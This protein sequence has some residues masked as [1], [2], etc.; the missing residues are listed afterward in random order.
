MACSGRKL[1]GRGRPCA[2]SPAGGCHQNCSAAR[3]AP[4]NSGPCRRG[5]QK[6][7]DAANA[8]SFR[9]PSRHGLGLIAPLALN[10]QSGLR[11]CARRFFGRCGL[12]PASLGRC[13]PA[14]SGACPI[15]AE[16]PCRSL[17]TATPPSAVRLHAR[18]VNQGAALFRAR[19][20]DGRRGGLRHAFRA[21]SDRCSKVLPASMVRS[22]GSRWPARARA[23]GWRAQAPLRTR[24]RRPDGPSIWFRARRR[25]RF[26]LGQAGLSADDA[27]AVL[28]GLRLRGWRYDKY[29]TKLAADKRPSL[30]TIHV[31]NAP[32]G[33]EAA[34]KREAA[35][36]KGCGICAYAGDRTGQ[37]D[38]SGEL[39][40]RLRTRLFP[41]PEWKSPCWA[42]PR[43]KRSAWARCW[44]WGKGFGAG[45]ET[46]GDSAGTAGSQATSRPS[47]RRQGGVTFDTGGISLKPP[48]G[49]GG[50]E[51]GHGRRRRSRRR[52]WL[53]LASR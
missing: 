24:G 45:I 9:G 53:A 18:V 27:A 3:S 12:H 5:T 13:A 2:A 20:R 50:H 23:R 46:A 17:F 31:T 14:S 4:R 30:E 29:R 47:F 44:A 40:C 43:W 36:A 21:G 35:L 26:D 10:S 1:P 28:L 33:T 34:W 52:G 51:V 48:P 39:R 16:T 22:G 38:L 42:R 25:W 11:P 15:L 37:C 6:P 7:G 8:R 19:H 49:I 41:A 32:E